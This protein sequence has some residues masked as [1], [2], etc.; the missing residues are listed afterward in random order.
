MENY[1][2]VPTSNGFQIIEALPD[3]RLNTLEGFSTED[4]ARGWLDSFLILLG[5]IDCM[6]GIASRG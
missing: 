1:H 5:L 6:S 4:D 3:G 2:I